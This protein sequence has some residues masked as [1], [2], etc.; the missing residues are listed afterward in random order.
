MAQTW[1]VTGCSTG[2]GR[3]LAELL[4]ERGENVIATARKPETLDDL[5]KVH[6]EKA[7]AV[8]LDV[9]SPGD[10]AGAL[11]AGRERF[12]RIDALVNNA[13]YGH[14]GSVE[15]APLEDA[16][17]MME[18]NFFGPL[19]LIKAVLPEMIARRS[20]QIVNIGSVAGQVGFPVL[21]YYCASKFAV[22]GLSESLGAELEPLG[23]KVTVVDLGPFET[24]FAASMS[25]VP[26]APHYDMAE[27]TRIAGNARW[28]V[29]DDAREGG[30]ALLAALAAPRPPR[31]LALGQQG[32]DVIELHEGYRAE[33]RAR[34]MP[35]TRLE[36]E[37]AG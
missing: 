30:R 16:R 24:Q 26:P 20:G 9:T 15:E 12:G 7:L 28:V 13:G 29:P 18:T 17:A 5:V 19:M 31:R 32:L 14:L 37:T 22:S 4:L 25:I 3:V 35:A 34:W 6:G 21:G 27:L 23:I 33:E 11:A 1:L 10:I 2:F 36:V 8:R